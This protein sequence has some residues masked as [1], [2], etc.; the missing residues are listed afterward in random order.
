MVA[1]ALGTVQLGMPYG[2]AN[3]A[4]RPDMA[5]AAAIVAAARAGGIDTL[6]TAQG[7]GEA[8]EVLGTVGV[9]DFR[10][11]TKIGPVPDGA[12]PGPWMRAAVEGSLIRLGITALDGLLLHTPDQLLG[13]RGGEIAEALDALGRAGLARRTG[14][15]IYG[16][17]AL[18]ALTA[19]HPPGLVQ[20]PLNLFDRRL[21]ESGWAAR[22]TAAGAEIHTRSAFLQGLL[23]LPPAER[24]AQFDRFA[25]VW[26]AWDAWQQATGIDAAEACLRFAR[27]QAPVSR[28]VVGVETAAQLEALLAIPDAP[29][30]SLPDLPRPVPDD[31][32]DP[33]RWVR[34]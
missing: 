23:L 32:I 5:E 29:L 24:P 7:Y 26:A 1:L 27:A 10:V 30:P 22:L 6:D 17:D 4:G 13:P 16:P 20:A 14:V 25:G 19:R 31:L 21:I 9:Q 2:I 18:D 3:R 34:A 8:E 12:E 11:V 28:V 33:S 15:S